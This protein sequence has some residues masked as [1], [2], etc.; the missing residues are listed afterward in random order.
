MERAKEALHRKIRP[1]RAEIQKENE[2]L[3][4]KT[5]TDLT[6]NIVVPARAEVDQ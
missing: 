2:E 1:K 3:M 5:Y 6:P 4:H